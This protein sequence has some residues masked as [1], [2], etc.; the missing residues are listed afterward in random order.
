MSRSEV[1]PSSSVSTASNVPAGPIDS[2]SQDILHRIQQVPVCQANPSRKPQFRTFSHVQEEE[3]KRYFIKQA[4][5][6][7]A[8]PFLQSIV[9]KEAVAVEYFPE[10]VRIVRGTLNGNAL[11][12]EFHDQPTLERLMEKSLTTGEFREADRVLDEYLSFLN[13]LPTSIRIPDA[14]LD[15]FGITDPCVRTPVPCLT[16]SPIDCIPH[17]IIVSDEHWLLLDHEW[18]FQFPMPRDL[19]VHRAVSSLVY[20]LQGPIRQ[21]VSP[22][23]PLTLY[24]GYGSSKYFIP[25]SWLQRVLATSLSPKQAM[26]IEEGIARF[27]E[28]NPPRYRNRIRKHRKLLCRPDEIESYSDQIVSHLI[29]LAKKLLNF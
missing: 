20:R 4:A 3:G 16:F 21:A 6:E 24:C 27:V 17:N 9:A 19:L 5:T 13:S 8:F 7:E 18:T 26:V 11:R 28:I 25:E 23:N 15:H 29:V 1:S 10:K 14:F 22:S 12:Y 2:S